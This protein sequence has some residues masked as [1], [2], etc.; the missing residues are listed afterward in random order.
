MVSEMGPCMFALFALFLFTL[1]TLSTEYAEYRG[2]RVNK[3]DGEKN[4]ILEYVALVQ[5]I[6]VISQGSLEKVGYV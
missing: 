1:S 6:V 4:T 5:T 3:G 2:Y